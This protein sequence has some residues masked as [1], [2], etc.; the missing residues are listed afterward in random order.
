VGFVKVFALAPEE[1][2]VLVTASPVVKT[3]ENVSRL[4][5]HLE[6]FDVAEKPVEQISERIRNL[7]VVRGFVDEIDVDAKVKN[8]THGLWT[9]R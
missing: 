3:V 4:T 6:A 5:R 1:S 8:Y 9:R 2:V 7:V